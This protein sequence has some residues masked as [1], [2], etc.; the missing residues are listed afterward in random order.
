LV[1]HLPVAEAAKVLGCSPNAVRQ[2]IR[3]GTLAAAKVGEQWYVDVASQPTPLRPTSADLLP[4]T[5]PTASTDVRR[6]TA[7]DD[8]AVAALVELLHEERSDRQQER[9]RGLALEEQLR[10]ARE[11][12][13]MWQERARNL[14]GEVGRL[15]ELLALPAHK[16]PDPSRRRWWERWRR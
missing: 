15:Q 16:E 3:R 4:G 14:E 9:T 13:A 7:A 12:A 8:E 6:V 2:R 11:T 1:D 5:T 10:V